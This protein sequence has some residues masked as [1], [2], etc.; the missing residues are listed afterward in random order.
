MF[1]YQKTSR[2]FAQIPEGAEDLGADEL[3][4]LGATGVATIHRGIHFTADKAAL[5][6]INYRTR[7][8][9]KILA[10][11][12]QFE[13]RSPDELYRKAR[14]IPWSELMLNDNHSDIFH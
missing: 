2:Y 7:L 8:I 12:S 5:Y 13:C 9:G 6:R 4:E 14:K 11:L 3:R 10:S 1:E